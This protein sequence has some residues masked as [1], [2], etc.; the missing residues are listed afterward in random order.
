M[1]LIQLHSCVLRVAFPSLI[2]YLK[3]VF[4][5]AQSMADILKLPKNCVCPAMSVACVALDRLNT[6]VLVVSHHSYLT[7][8][9]VRCNV[10]C[11][12][13]LLLMNA[14]QLVVLDNYWNPLI[15]FVFLPAHLVQ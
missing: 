12:Q 7:T 11:I 6:I 13:I 10:L 15:K 8:H 5:F 2:Y 9:L 4:N 14:F 1:L 3:L